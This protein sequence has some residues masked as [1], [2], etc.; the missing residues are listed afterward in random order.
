[1]DNDTDLD[2]QPINLMTGWKQILHCYQICSKNI[3]FKISIRHEIDMILHT[4]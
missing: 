1:M 2:H 3:I 4:H